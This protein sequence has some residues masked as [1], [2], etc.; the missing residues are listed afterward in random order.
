M[1]LATIQMDL[2]SI[3]LSVIIWTKK[4]KFSKLSLIC[5]NQKINVHNK[6]LTDSQIQRT[7]QQLPVEGRMG[8]G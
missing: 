8:E 7:N 4:E 6:T 5:E 3:T 2:E 1:S